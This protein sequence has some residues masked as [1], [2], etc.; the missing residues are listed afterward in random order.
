MKDP[1]KV[2]I[3]R[4][5]TP[6]ALKIGGRENSRDLLNVSRAALKG[7]LGT[8]IAQLKDERHALLHQTYEGTI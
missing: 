2:D 6:L 7:L 4:S 1:D 5:N 3:F 8:A